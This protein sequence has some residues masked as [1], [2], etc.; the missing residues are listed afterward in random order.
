MTEHTTRPEAEQDRRAMSRFVPHS[1]MSTDQVMECSYQAAAI[2]RL[3]ESATW[4]IQNGEDS[5]S[6]SDAIG[7]G[8]RLAQ[9]L[10]GVMHN[11]L[12]A[13]HEDLMSQRAAQAGDA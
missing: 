10:N 12:A 11:A 5:T 3:C 1:D 9:E 4:A 8:L 7:A 2:I 6:L 13:T